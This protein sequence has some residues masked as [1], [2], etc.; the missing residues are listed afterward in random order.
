MPLL[1]DAVAMGHG[2]HG[3]WGSQPAKDTT[4]AWKMWRR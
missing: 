4:I 1:A 3:T 2:D